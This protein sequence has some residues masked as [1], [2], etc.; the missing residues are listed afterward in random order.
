MTVVGGLG[1]LAVGGMQTTRLVA[2]FR[3]GTAFVPSECAMS[4]TAL[5]GCDDELE[6]FAESQR[7]ADAHRE[8]GRQ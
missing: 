1:S 7:F 8:R 3:T 5:P 2:E 4:A 6:A